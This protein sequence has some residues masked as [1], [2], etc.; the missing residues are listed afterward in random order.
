MLEL[1]R[2]LARI[3]IC[4]KIIMCGKPSKK[5]AETLC[6][7]AKSTET[8]ITCRFVL[9]QEILR[10]FRLHRVWWIYFVKLILSDSFRKTTEIFTKL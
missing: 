8:D 6:D 3:Y 5:V 7:L 4:S 10:F 1:V 2:R 9:R